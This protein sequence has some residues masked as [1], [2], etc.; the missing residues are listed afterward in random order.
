MSSLTDDAPERRRRTAT[1]P[2]DTIED[3]FELSSFECVKQDFVIFYA[4][5]DDDGVMWC[6]VSCSTSASSP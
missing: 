5:R 6:P 3:P 2:L 1:M 4:G